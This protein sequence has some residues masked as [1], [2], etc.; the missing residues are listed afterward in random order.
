MF[1]QKDRKM[2]LALQKIISDGDFLL[3]GSAVPGFVMILQWIKE[4]QDKIED[5]LKPKEED[6]K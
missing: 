1:K 6:K 5:D 3:K 4:L 2:I